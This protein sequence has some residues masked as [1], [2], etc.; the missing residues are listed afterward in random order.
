MTEA[1]FKI[2]FNLF[3]NNEN[4]IEQFLLLLSK[5]A[6]D[7]INNGERFVF[8][9]MVSENVNLNH[10]IFRLFLLARSNNFVMC[11]EVLGVIL[12]PLWPGELNFLCRLLHIFSSFMSKN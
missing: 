12:D 1:S 5:S 4:L 8:Y 11:S 6:P 3:F 9:Q 2:I 10:D 7:I